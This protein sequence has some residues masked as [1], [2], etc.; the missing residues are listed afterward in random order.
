MNK[1]RIPKAIRKRL[2]LLRRLY[3]PNRPHFGPHLPWDHPL[4]VERRRNQLIDHIVRPNTLLASL[5]A[6]GLVR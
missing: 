1:K 2:K 4:A 3:R 5:Q 6:A